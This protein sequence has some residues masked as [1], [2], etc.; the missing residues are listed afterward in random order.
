MQCASYISPYQVNSF[1]LLFIVPP[2]AQIFK[3][4]QIKD[5]LFIVGVFFLIHLSLHPTI[6]MK[7]VTNN[8]QNSKL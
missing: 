7:K 5:G 2:V 6:L 4:T 3:W 8:N 1:Q